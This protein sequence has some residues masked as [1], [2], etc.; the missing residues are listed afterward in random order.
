[1][2]NFKTALDT[3]IRSQENNQKFAQFLAEVIPLGFLY[4]IL[5]VLVMVDQRGVA[6][7]DPGL[8]ALISCP[9]NQISQYEIL[10]E[11]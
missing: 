11:V 2:K 7:D 1:V 9:L 6:S 8:M 10:L 5:F 3:L 4:S